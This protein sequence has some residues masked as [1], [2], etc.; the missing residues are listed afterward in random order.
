M[1]SDG[2]LDTVHGTRERTGG[3]LA[4]GEEKSVSGMPS[5]L[6]PNGS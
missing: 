3:C 4:R 2:G 5:P 6:I 1:L